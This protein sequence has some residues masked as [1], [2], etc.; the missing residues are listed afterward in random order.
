MDSPGRFSSVTLYCQRQ[1]CVH[2]PWF[3]S[4][5]AMKLESRQRPEYEIHIA[6]CTKVS[7]SISAGMRSRISR[8]SASESSLAVTT[9]LAPSSRQ[10]R[11]VP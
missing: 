4:R 9:R 11:K 3:A 2:S 5:P 7:I 6:P 8:I 10:K 1:G